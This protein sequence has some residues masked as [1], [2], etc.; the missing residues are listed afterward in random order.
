MG[1]GGRKIQLQRLGTN[2]WVRGINAGLLA[3]SQF[4]SGRSCDRP[5]QSRLSVVFLG[6]RANAESVPKFHIALHAS[7]V[8]LLMVA[9]E[10][11]HCTKVTSKYGDLALQVGGVSDEKVK[12]G[13][14]FCGTST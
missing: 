11:S 12:Y 8:A 5:V 2:F 6:P 1:G 9:L 10:I 7:H 3:R 4:A 14:E 13:L